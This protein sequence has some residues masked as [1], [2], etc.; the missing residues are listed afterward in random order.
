MPQT[1]TSTPRDPLRRA[2]GQSEHVQDKVERAA[3]G[4]G[5]VNATLKG[6][7]GL[8]ITPAELEVART[9][10][11]VIKD[12]V[13]E[14]ADELVTVNLML[15]DEILER[16]H[17]EAELEKSQSALAQSQAEA[18][19]SNHA[20]LHDPLTG[21]PNATL[22]GD[23]LENAL[24]QAGRRGSLLAVMFIDLNRFKHIND[25]HGHEVGDRVLA[26]VAKRLEGLVREGDT[27]SRRSGDEFLF[28]MV[29]PT[30]PSHVAALATRIADGIAKPLQLDGLSLSL[31]ASIGVA[32]F[33]GD[34]AT[35]G[36]L[37][38]R[39]DATMYGAKRIRSTSD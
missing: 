8:G 14:A 34:G 31:S 39:A 22:F 6:D 9:K 23:R 29:D 4:L 32:C 1:P 16:R 25:T 13:Q 15:N 35:S 5:S 20:A 18:E 3:Q 37:L 38:A 19:A 24:A 12:R 26:V 36:E 11:E 27:V 2:L 30:D 33:P 10:S 28:L 17:L 7:V 21:L